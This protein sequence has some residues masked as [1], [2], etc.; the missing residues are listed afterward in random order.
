MMLELETFIWNISQI[1]V[2]VGI[3]ILRKSRFSLDKSLIIKRK[4]WM[5]CLL[6]EDFEA[7]ASQRRN[8]LLSNNCVRPAISFLWGEDLV[9]QVW[10]THWTLFLQPVG[11]LLLPGENVAGHT[12]IHTHPHRVVYNW[13]KLTF[14]SRKQHVLD[15]SGHKIQ[16]K[17][18]QRQPVL[19]K[20]STFQWKLGWSADLLLMF[21]KFSHIQTA[22]TKQINKYISN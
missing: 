13:S 5:P 3:F 1:S 19:F 7:R 8:V 14:C 20:K 4:H 2:D 10:V 17:I 15:V 18:V 21:E 12:H 22:Q 11:N 9:I 16:E 6:I